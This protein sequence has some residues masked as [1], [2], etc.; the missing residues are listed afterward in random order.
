MHRSLP[1]VVLMMIVS[2][3]PPAARP[4][5]ADA[6]VSPGV[7]IAAVTPVQNP[8]QTYALYLPKRYSP[9]SRWPVVYV[10]D[11]LARGELALKQFEH[12]AELH[13]FIIAASNHSRNGPWAPQFEAAQAMVN[14]T[15]KRFSV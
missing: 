1:T 15:Q 11:P 5:S 8:Q 10:F 14:D 4:Q 13:G 3:H 7:V 6:P 12:A 9:L 2:V